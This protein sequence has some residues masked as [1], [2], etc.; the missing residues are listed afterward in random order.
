MTSSFVI[1]NGSK[2]SQYV[3]NWIKKVLPEL[4]YPCLHWLNTRLVWH[5]SAILKVWF[6]SW[7]V[8]RTPKRSCSFMAN[9][10]SWFTPAKNKIINNCKCYSV[11][12][13]QILYYSCNFINFWLKSSQTLLITLQIRGQ[14][15]NCVWMRDLKLK[16]S[17]LSNYTYRQGY[18]TSYLMRCSPHVVHPPRPL[19]NS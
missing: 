6:W 8:G 9:L 12:G 11:D 10:S 5:F 18:S 3:T 17:K 14:S 2:R 16:S 19:R 13:F 7:T 15:W 4:N 1:P